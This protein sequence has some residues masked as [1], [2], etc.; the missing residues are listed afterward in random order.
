MFN[1]RVF[2]VAALIFSAV[3]AN[4]AI[5][6]TFS[7]SGSVGS[8]A[9]SSPSFSFGTF[10]DPATIDLE[11]TAADSDA[12]PVG[13]T[14]GGFVEIDVASSDFAYSIG[15]TPEGFND[16]F[17]SS[18][19]VTASRVSFFTSV[20]TFNWPGFDGHTLRT[21]LIVDFGSSLL[22]APATYGELIS[23]LNA[24]G[25][26]ALFRTNGDFLFTDDI[27]FDEYSVVSTVAAVPLP[28]GLPLLLAGIGG[29]GLM[30]R[31]RQ[32]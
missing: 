12:I 29:F 13:P 10:G 5:A 15:F 22:S 20:G 30:A 19:S 2:A 32:S 9:I 27:V 3:F 18:I 6:A 16:G 8:G 26:T 11:I 23:A 17:N 31:R 7:F 28:A 21:G 14:S 25:A 4:Q 24:P 1:F